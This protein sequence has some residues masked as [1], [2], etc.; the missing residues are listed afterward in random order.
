MLP[1]AL[2]KTRKW[3]CQFFHPQRPRERPTSL[4]QRPNWTSSIFYIFANLSGDNFFS[5]QPS[6]SFTPPSTCFAQAPGCWQPKAFSRRQNEVKAESLLPFSR[7]VFTWVKTVQVKCLLGLKGEEARSEEPPPRCVSQPP[8]PNLWIRAFWSATMWNMSLQLFIH[9]IAI[10]CYDNICVLIEHR[11]VV[12][13]DITGGAILVFLIL[14]GLC[15]LQISWVP[16]REGRKSSHMAL[17]SSWPTLFCLV[18]WPLN[19]PGSLWTMFLDLEPPWHHFLSLA[20]DLC[21]V[22]GM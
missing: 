9:L 10:H 19:V 13:R 4:Q 17:S 2:Q 5:S 18:T 21:A 7:R 12:G 15:P 11:M 20:Q 6:G 1:D 22:L 8:H 3:L 14:C 16:R